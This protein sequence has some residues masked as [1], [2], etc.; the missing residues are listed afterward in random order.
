MANGF[1]VSQDWIKK[2]TPLSKNVDI[3]DIYPFINIAQDK[4]IKDL[5]GSKF[6]DSLKTKL[7]ASTLSAD[8][9]TLLKLVR[10]CLAYYICYEAIPFLGTKIRNK[11]ILEANGENLNNADVNTVKYLRQG[12]L[13]AAE[14]YLKR[15]QEYLCENHTL[16][17][18]YDSPDN[19][20]WP[21][22]RVGT[23]CDIAF[24]V[25]DP[26][27]VDLKWIRKYLS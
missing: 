26:Y 21:S 25:S 14:Y 23:S 11:G 5:L 1:F 4:Y 7:I 17:A 15:V 3:A 16:F 8:E 22:N 9:I 27:H 19:P 6:F 10:P 2:N 20:I 13:G 24:D 12:C 18:D